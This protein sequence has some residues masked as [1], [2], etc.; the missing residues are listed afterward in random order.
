M[1]LPT[2]PQT[3]VGRSPLTVRVLLSGTPKVGKTTL[4]SSW[5]PDR[6]LIIDTQG[7]THHLDGE[8]FVSHVATWPEF[9]SVVDELM[10]PGHQFECVV[11]DMIDDLWN[12][13]DKHY[14]GKGAELATA[15]EDYQRAAR[16]AE[17]AFRV[18]IG[19]LAASPL[20]L[21]MLSHV[22]EIVEDSRSRFKSKLDPRV[23]TYVQGVCDFV[24]LAE[25]VGPKRL[26]HTQP[27]ARFE[28]GS[29]RPLPDPM[30]LDARALYAAVR[31]AL[32]DDTETI[33][34]EVAA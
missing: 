14:A 3:R 32:G 5:A 2:E 11:I 34:T 15:T 30:D 13:V 19:R 25:A 26:L 21:W 17:G 33:E 8:H 12:F 24:F 4:A 18:Q 1:A 29:R 22:R 16:N 28:A 27:S 20:G 6:T 23:L 31:D 9:V 10:K 7:G